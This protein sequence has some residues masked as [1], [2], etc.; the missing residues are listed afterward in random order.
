MNFYR[1]TVSARLSAG[2]SVIVIL[3]IALGVVSARGMLRTRD[4]T[5]ALLHK[6]LVAERAMHSWQNVIELNLVRSFAAGKTSDPAEQQALEADMALSSATAT[7][8]QQLIAENMTDS[9]AHELMDFATRERASYRDARAIAFREKA[10]GND[11]EAARFFTQELRPIAASYSAAV[12]KLVAHQQELMNDTGE[13]ISTRSSATLNMVIAVSLVA[14]LIAIVLGYQISRSLLRQLGGEPSYAA[15][16]TARIASGDLSQHVVIRPGDRDSL[17]LSIS[18]MRDSLVSIVG[19]V[20]AGTDI[21][22]MSSREIAGG[23][24]DLSARTEQQAASL[25]ETASS[26]EDFTETARQNGSNAR[27]ASQLVQTAAAVAGDGRT[28]VTQMVVT[29]DSI[30]G[31][32]RKMADI[33]SVI[34]S[35]A[36]QTNILALN[37]AVEAARAGEQGRGF[38]VVAAEVR[39]LAQRTTGA[40][41]E[42]KDLID[43]S[44]QQV[45]AGNE[46]AANVGQTMSLIVSSVERVS[47]MIND[48]SDASAIQSHGVEHIKEAVVAMDTATQQNAALSEQTAST[49]HMLEESALRLS[50]S[51][52]RFTLVD[53]LSQPM[54]FTAS[55]DTTRLQGARRVQLNV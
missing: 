23:I 3:L 34:D 2:F 42:I 26:M 29:M 7:K 21:V 13:A 47:V 19:D 9:R 31:S 12:A 46:L 37:A 1:W 43:A 53:D 51:V 40:A 38:A 48:V 14:I 6:Q 10:A 39:H 17:L 4:D 15:A 36:F 45:T 32:A 27:E 55:T 50:E 5:V 16:V 52:S 8:L 20:R 44:V 18:K 49:A 25:E 30:E 11:A 33:I 22:L 54:V 41:K 28:A 35:I 24:S